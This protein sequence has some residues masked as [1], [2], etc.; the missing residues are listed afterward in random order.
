LDADNDGGVTEQEWLKRAQG[1]AK[2][3]GNP[4]NEAQEK[5]NF[6][7]HDANRDGVIS[8]EEL[9]KGGR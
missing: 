8:R 1:K 4:Y 5:K 2:K 9:D 3:K 6:T 7:G